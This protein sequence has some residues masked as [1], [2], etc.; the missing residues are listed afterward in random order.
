VQFLDWVY[1]SSEAETDGNSN[2]FYMNQERLF[3]LTQPLYT[4]LKCN[5]TIVRTLLPPS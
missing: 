1:T 2:G 4:R 5:G 3:Q